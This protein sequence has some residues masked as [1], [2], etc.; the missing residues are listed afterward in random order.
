MRSWL[1]ETMINDEREK[2]A[3]SALVET[4]LK[5][6]I[7]KLKS[8]KLSIASEIDLKQRQS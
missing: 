7:E 4:D 5:S 3:S 1:S 2:M 6:T 8:E